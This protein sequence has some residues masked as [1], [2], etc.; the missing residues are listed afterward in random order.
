MAYFR[1]ADTGMMDVFCN[2]TLSDVQKARLQRG[3]GKVQL[4]HF[5]ENVP[6]N[7]ARPYFEKSD[8]VFGNPP[9]SWIV[10]HPSL[11]WVQ[12][13][14]VGFGEYLS[15][16]WNTLGNR[17]TIT[18]LSGFFS[19][20]VAESILAGVLAFYR[21]ID[22]LVL[23]KHAADWQGDL[24][25]PSL[26][27]LHG[28]NVVLF[29]QGAVN[30]RFADLIA[31]FGCSITRF[32]RGW[33]TASLNKSLAQ[34][35]LVVSTVPDTPETRGVFD[36]GRLNHMKRGSIFANFGRG[37]VVHDDALADALEGGLLMGAVIDVTRDEPLPVEH[38]FWRTPNLILTQHS[39]GGTGNEIDRKIEWFL[40]NFGRY[41]R[42]EKLHAVV[43][44]AR[45][46]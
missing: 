21:G 23:L 33:E 38:R 26:R 31:P 29:G 42:G 37:S 2:L 20:P 19:D 24:L 25:R 14:S 11:C 36:R 18:N 39:G 28:A 3:L 17:L 13:E 5:D 44:F 8:I 27:T 22:R 35:D 46:Y 43:D 15:L 30:A 32:G 7:I 4:H 41:Q 45:G 10:T 12:L 1:K 40:D 9:S 16:N 6:E 34:A